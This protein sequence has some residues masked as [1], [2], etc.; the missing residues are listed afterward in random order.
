MTKHDPAVYTALLDQ[1]RRLEAIEDALGMGVAG[2]GQRRLV[3]LYHD[4]LDPGDITERSGRS[5]ARL[6]LT[7]DSSQLLVLVRLTGDPFPYQGLLAVLDA[8]AAQEHDVTDAREHLLKIA[9]GLLNA[10]GLELIRP[11]DVMGMPPLKTRAARTIRR[12]L[13][14]SQ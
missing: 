7:L 9:Q 1:D 3:E 5:W 10:Q 2:M 6:T 4:S 11:R 14:G 12:D 13:G 8:H